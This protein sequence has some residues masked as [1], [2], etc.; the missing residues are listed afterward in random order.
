MDAIGHKLNS[1][2]IDHKNSAECTAPSY[3]DNALLFDM[4]KR[5]LRGIVS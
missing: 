1:T 2:Q 5:I 4:T 3:V